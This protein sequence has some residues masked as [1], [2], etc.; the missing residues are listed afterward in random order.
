MKKRI[1]TV[2]LALFLVWGGVTSKTA[3]ANESA[4]FSPRTSLANIF[5][6]G[7]FGAVLGLS[8][9]SFTSQPSKHMKNIL[10][11]GA[12]GIIAGVVYVAYDAATTGGFGNQAYY[13]HGPEESM[14]AN[15]SLYSASG[16]A[17]AFSQSHQPEGISA[18]GSLP[19]GVSWSTE[20]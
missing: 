4:D 1:L 2:F 17:M 3:F 15:R 6:L 10:I 11:G 13:L 5:Y 8:T 19:L 18:D 7:A 20:F 14:K 9:L 16:S 12:L